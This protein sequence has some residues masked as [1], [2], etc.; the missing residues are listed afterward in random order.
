MRERCKAGEN[1]E[2]DFK[3]FNAIAKL[4]K[5]SWREFVMKHPFRNVE[6]T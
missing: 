4:L 3:A 5:G 2:V 1:E 6:I